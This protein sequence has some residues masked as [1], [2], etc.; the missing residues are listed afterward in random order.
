MVPE[1][2]IS[3]VIWG[4]LGLWVLVAL[5]L[6]WIRRLQPSAKARY[7]GRLGWI[8]AAALPL[9]I[10]LL[11]GLHVMTLFLLGVLAT[12][13]GLSARFT[14]VCQQ[15]GKTSQALGAR[16]WYCGRCGAPLAAGALRDRSQP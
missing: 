15:C 16:N 2:Y 6:L 12:M 8:N 9:A 1:S 11:L 7:Q 10:V 13:M 5:N 4:Y 14:R 3:A